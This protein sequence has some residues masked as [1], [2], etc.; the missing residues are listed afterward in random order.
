VTVAARAND[1]WSQRYFAQVLSARSGER[2]E[3][4]S[5]PS[6]VSAAVYSSDG[7]WLAVQAASGD[8]QQIWLYPSTEGWGQLFHEVAAESGRLSL[9]GWVGATGAEAEP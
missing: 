6:R 7:K 1:F 2:I 3:E 5:L 4:F 9:L 8:S